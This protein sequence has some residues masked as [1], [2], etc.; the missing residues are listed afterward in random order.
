MTVNS[1]FFPDAN[2][3]STVSP[4]VRSR[5]VAMVVSMS[6]LFGADRSVVPDTRGKVDTSLTVPASTPVMVPL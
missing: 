2:V 3:S 6:T 1:C 5:F 4:T